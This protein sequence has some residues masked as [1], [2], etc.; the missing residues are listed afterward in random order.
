MPSGFWGEK[1]LVAS[2]WGCVHWAQKGPSLVLCAF[3]FSQM[4]ISHLGGKSSGALNVQISAKVMCCVSRWE[5]R[6]LDGQPI[7]GR[8]SSP[9]SKAGDVVRRRQDSHLLHL[10]VH[11]PGQAPSRPLAPLCHPDPSAQCLQWHL[12]HSL[13]SP[14]RAHCTRGSDSAAGGRHRAINPNQARPATYLRRRCHV[15]DVRGGASNP[16]PS[17]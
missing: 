14:P 4:I 15:C 3:L 13:P 16:P 2:E 8:E 10:G 7:E 5:G 6:M 9:V 12:F 17:S 1:S 11:L